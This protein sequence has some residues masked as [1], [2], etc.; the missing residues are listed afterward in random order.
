MDQHLPT[1]GCKGK[2]SSIQTD[3]SFLLEG[4]HSLGYSCIQ[5]KASR[6]CLLKGMAYSGRSLVTYSTN[7]G[8]EPDNATVYHIPKDG[9]EVPISVSSFKLNFFVK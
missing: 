5:G 2:D 9:P 4:H 6:Y 3:G 8:I 1:C 7:V